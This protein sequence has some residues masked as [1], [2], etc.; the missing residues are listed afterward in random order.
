MRWPSRILS[1]LVVAVLGAQGSVA[2]AQ[3]M[4]V[5]TRPVVDEFLGPAGSLPNPDLW[6]FD[7]GTNK[8]YHWEKG[9]L[10]DYTNAPDNVR[11]DGNGHLVI[12]ARKGGS[13]SV[14]SYTNDHPRT[15]GVSLRRGVGADQVSDRAGDLVGLLDDGAELRHRGLA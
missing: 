14:P 4:P 12:Q 5:A 10:Q 2:D 3:G 6:A 9:S 15:N 8:K 7:V 11:L 1:A 13:D